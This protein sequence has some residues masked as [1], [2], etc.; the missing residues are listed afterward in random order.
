MVE[1]PE[2][3]AENWIFHLAFEMLLTEFLR[4]AGKEC[5]GPHHVEG[6]IFERPI[7]PEVIEIMEERYVVEQESNDCGVGIILTRE[8]VCCTSLVN[9]ERFNYWLDLWDHLSS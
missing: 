6:E 7:K 3:L 4:F 1:R 2:F 8:T 5:L 9:G